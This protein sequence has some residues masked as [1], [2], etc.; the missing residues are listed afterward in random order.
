MRSVEKVTEVWNESLAYAKRKDF[1]S[2]GL[3]IASSAALGGIAVALWNRHALTA[4][5]EVQ[6][7]REHS[8]T[9]EE[10]FDFE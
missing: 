9:A 8:E 4:M 1:W 5:R 10:F 3:L 2:T 7:I 6:G